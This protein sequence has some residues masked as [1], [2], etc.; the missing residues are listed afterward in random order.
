MTR[1]TLIVGGG[2]AGVLLARQLCRST[3]HSVVLVDPAHRPGAG[4]A[5]G[6]ADAWHLLNSPAATM[7]AD[8]DEPGH[9][10]AWADAAGSPISAGDFA[11]R[12]LYGR[13]LR[14][15]LADTVDTGR[16]RI[17]RGTVAAIGG[18]DRLTAYLDGGA[19]LTASDVI[20]AIG[21][22]AVDTVIPGLVGHP[23]YIPD[24]WRPGAFDDIADGP[25]LLIGTGLTAVDVALSL[26]LLRPRV[27]VDAVSRH[28]LLPRSHRS[29]DEVATVQTRAPAPDPSVARQFAA[30]RRSV[31]HTGDWRAVMDGLRPHVDSLW[32]GLDPAAQR[33]FI[34]HGARYWEVHRHRMAPQVARRVDRLQADGRLVVS[35]DRVVAVDSTRDAG[36]GVA[37][38]RARSRDYAAVVNCTGPARLPAG[39]NRLVTGLLGDG[40]ARVGPHDLGLDV[41]ERGRLID[42][43]GRTHRRLWVVGA[44]RRGRLWETTAVPE[45]RRQAQEVAAAIIGTPADATQ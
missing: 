42:R 33:R 28:G 26:T 24:P 10:M 5:Y 19:E 22:P 32:Q 3:E 16:L 25:V 14:A 18:D 12:P 44:M 39:A 35:A 31:T 8:P 38:A 15:I 37:F 2:A 43:H 7:S 29:A 20:I 34:E 41:D 1:T 6:Q 40:V 13:Y 17:V 23:R 11:P 9:F 27:S 30:I 4:P 45:I 36:I 21:N